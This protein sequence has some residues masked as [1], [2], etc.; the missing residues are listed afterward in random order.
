MKAKIVAAESGSCVA[1]SVGV[2][3]VNALSDWLGILGSSG[4]VG[5]GTTEPLYVEDKEAVLRAG[6]T[7]LSAFR[8][9]VGQSPF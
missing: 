7:V 6:R 5:V 9:T 8:T 4:F 2:S 3:A 1:I